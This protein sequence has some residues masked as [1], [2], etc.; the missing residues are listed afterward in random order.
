MSLVAT[1]AWSIITRKESLWVKW[2]HEYRLKGRSFWEVPITADASW[3]KL[4]NIRDA[5]R[6]FIVS[7]IGNG[8]STS[9]WFDRWCHISPLKSF[10]SCR[11]I[12]YAGFNLQ[13]KV[14]DLVDN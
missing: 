9:A 12:S 1:H 7:I 2:I 5:I 6:S 3:R 11:D 14:S 8:K 4:L 10:I 13:N